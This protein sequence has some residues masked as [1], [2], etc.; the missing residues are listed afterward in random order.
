MAHKSQQAIYKQLNNRLNP[1][2]QLVDNQKMLETRALQE[3]FGI[4]VEQPIQP[5]LNNQFNQETP[6]YDILKGELEAKNKQI[7]ELTTELIKE[8]AHSREQSERMAVLADQAQKLQLA[9]MK[10]QLTDGG[11]DPQ[12]E[13]PP[14]KK[15]SLFYRLFGKEK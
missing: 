12:A 4:E 15:P 6:L 8:R 10:P 7:E 2:I 13:T 11:A 1:Y 5:K 9:Q 3:V 14:Q